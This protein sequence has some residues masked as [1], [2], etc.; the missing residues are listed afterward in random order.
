MLVLYFGS[1]S[2]SVVVLEIEYG[3][4]RIYFPFDKVLFELYFAPLLGFF[5]RVRICILFS[6]VRQRFSCCVKVV[7]KL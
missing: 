4:G 1:I 3:S 6:V 5:Y 2:P 7:R